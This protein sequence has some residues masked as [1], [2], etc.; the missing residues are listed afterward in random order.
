M[1]GR[2]IARERPYGWSWS[3][4]KPI[5]RRLDKADTEVEAAGCFGFESHLQAARSFARQ[6]TVQSVCQQHAGKSSSLKGVLDASHRGGYCGQMAIRLL[7][8]SHRIWAKTWTTGWSANQRGLRRGGD[9][10]VLHAA[11]SGEGGHGGNSENSLDIQWGVPNDE[12]QSDC[13]DRGER[14]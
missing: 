9:G 12:A 7:V 10:S 5:N 11:K 1:V 4:Q 13:V 8:H 6:A 14:V 3:N 2:R